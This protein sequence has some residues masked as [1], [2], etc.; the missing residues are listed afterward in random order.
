MSNKF[1][2]HGSYIRSNLVLITK[3]IGTNSILAH[4]WHHQNCINVISLVA[5]EI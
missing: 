4:L 1:Q 2:F 5:L 3:I